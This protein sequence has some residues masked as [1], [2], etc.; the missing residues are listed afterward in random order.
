MAP[1]A[2]NV[3]NVAKV[4]DGQVPG[5]VA[6]IKSPSFD[7]SPRGNDTADG[8]FRATT[9]RP[10]R[11][12]NYQPMSFMERIL[13]FLDANPNLSL[14]NQNYP[15]YAA[16][17]PRFVLQS[18]IQ[19][20]VLRNNF[21]VVHDAVQVAD[22]LGIDSRATVEW[23]ERLSEP[24]QPEISADDPS[25]AGG[26]ISAE[27]H[28]LS[29]E[30][31]QLPKFIG[32][33]ANSSD[34]PAFVYAYY[35]GQESFATNPTWES[36][37]IHAHEVRG[38]MLSGEYGTILDFLAASLVHEA[39]R[40]DFLSTAVQL[41]F[42]TTPEKEHSCI[43]GSHMPLSGESA[44]N[45]V[46]MRSWAD[47]STTSFILTLNFTE[48]PKSRYL[49]QP[50]SLLRE[51]GGHGFSGVHADP[52]ALSLYGSYGSQ[53]PHAL[54]GGHGVGAVH[55]SSEGPG[56]MLVRKTQQRIK[57][58]LSRNDRNDASGIISEADLLTEEQMLAS[59]LPLDQVLELD[60]LDIDAVARFLH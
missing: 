33:M 23:C 30:Y 2:G 14:G 12:H 45:L 59:M 32:A 6:P 37:V 19:S 9:Y 29:V 31:M 18:A 21:Q 60:Q 17:L 20:A 52:D 8:R 4:N 35:C 51:Q 10:Q 41:V 55:H 42:A 5:R 36:Q 25:P 47:E 22:K 53:G 34:M 3:E 1:A 16:V 57:D 40:D 15:N 49:A 38:R 44:M 28:V 58:V 13:D 26:R 48:L 39:D 56:A 46:R 27:S 43:L 54:L 24:G 7:G 11:Q 50:V